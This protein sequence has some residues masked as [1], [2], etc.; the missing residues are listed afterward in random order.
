MIHEAIGW[1]YSLHSVSPTLGYLVFSET[2]ERTA[3]ETI[4]Y[5]VQPYSGGIALLHMH[6]RLKGKKENCRAPRCASGLSPLS[7]PS[8]APQWG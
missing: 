7:T 1:K 6:V 4:I 5:D 2:G 8:E 3:P